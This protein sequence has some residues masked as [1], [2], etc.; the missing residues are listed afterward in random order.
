MG[1][2]QKFLKG[3]YASQ[4]FSPKGKR[5]FP[6]EATLPP[7]EIEKLNSDSRP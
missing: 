5:S 2:H 6:R 4:K 1:L 3:S 7:K